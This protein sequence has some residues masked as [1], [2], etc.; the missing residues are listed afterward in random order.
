MMY[1]RIFTLLTVFFLTASFAP[2]IHS[3]F[4]VYRV[5]ASTSAI[6]LGSS[7][8][9]SISYFLLSPE[10]ARRYVGV[11]DLNFPGPS[12]SGNDIYLTGDVG[13]RKSEFIP[14]F[15]SYRS[16]EITISTLSLGD[17]ITPLESVSRSLVEQLYLITKPSLVGAHLKVSDGHYN[18]F[19]KFD[20]PMPDKIERY[21]FSIQLDQR[22]AYEEWIKKHTIDVLIVKNEHNRFFR[23][24]NNHIL[25]EL[26]HIGDP[27]LIGPESIGGGGFY[28][29][30]PKFSEPMPERI[31]VLRLSDNLAERKIY[32]DW[33]AEHT[34]EVIKVKKVKDDYFLSGGTFDTREF[35]GDFQRD[36][37]VG[38]VV[39]EVVERTTFKDRPFARVAMTFATSDEI[40]KGVFRQEYVQG[41]TV[42]HLKELFDKRIAGQ[43]DAECL[44][45]LASFNL[46]TDIDHR[47]ASLEQMYRDS[48]AEVIMWLRKNEL[49]YYSNTVEDGI[50]QQTYVVGL[51]YN[52]GE[53][54]IWDMHQQMFVIID[55]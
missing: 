39:R 11:P 7:C 29:V 48:F 6:N 50:F 18:V 35:I 28:T 26:Y 42:R 38:A 31:S 49:T 27:R 14:R 15:Y 13:A 25:A 37:A 23:K 10:S 16:A 46:P 40:A 8:L 17:S 41:P 36:L 2:K 44:R 52:H 32:D 45:E 12:G 54:V 3:N 53:N 9:G 22:R 4:T 43:C 19:A 30:F 34:V 55:W 47:I 33:V 5:P 24:I 20:M 51:D 1:I 21:R